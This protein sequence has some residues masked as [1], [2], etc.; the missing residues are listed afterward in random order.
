MEEDKIR[1]KF[2]MGSFLYEKFID[3]FT[4]EIRNSIM[5]FIKEDSKVID[6][7][8]GTG[9]L[10]FELAKK[11][12]YVMGFDLSED[13]IAYN[14]FK[15]DKYNIDNVD[16]LQG[17]ATKLSELVGTRFDYATISLAL[18]EHPVEKRDIIIRELGEIADKIIVADFTSPK[19]KNFW[20]GLVSTVEFFSGKEH[21]TNQLNFI[22]TGGIEQLLNK[23]GYTI[24]KQERKNSEVFNIIQATKNKL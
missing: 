23:N 17:D 22:K 21:F 2:S 15:K 18:H 13:S 16:F 10:V 5:E 4:V 19:P 11:S 9:A 14:L 8:C 3:P 7:A 12:R 6:I 20:S 1:K 24:E